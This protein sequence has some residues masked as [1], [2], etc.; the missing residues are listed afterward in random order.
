[1]S[2]NER[3]RQGLEIIQFSWFSPDFVTGDFATEIRMGYP[4]ED[5]MRKPFRGVQLIGNFLD[6]LANVSWSGET[7]FYGNYLDPQA[8]RFND[9]KL[10]G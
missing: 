10:A 3:L 1:M 5:G 4:V 7:G 8:A 6:A 2:S 9:L